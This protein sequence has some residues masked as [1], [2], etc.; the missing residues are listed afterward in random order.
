MMWKAS[1]GKIH[2]TV[3]RLRKLATGNYQK[4]GLSSRNCVDEPSFL[5]LR[6]R[7]G[8]CSYVREAGGSPGGGRGPPG[9]GTH[10]LCLLREATAL[11]W[12]GSWPLSPSAG[13]NQNCDPRGE[14]EHLKVAF[15]GTLSGYSGWK[16]ASSR[17]SA[18]PSQPRSKRTQT[19][20]GGT[21]AT[22]TPIRNWE[23]PHTNMWLIHWDWVTPAE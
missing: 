23:T 7:A 9:K 19:G 20:V 17:G 15:H 14:W 18:P 6:Y 10:E 1:E 8:E 4:S 12:A 11:F 21:K 22:T 13:S 3:R 5:I 2:P 16:R